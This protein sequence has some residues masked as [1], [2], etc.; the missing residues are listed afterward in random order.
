MVDLLLAAGALAW[1][2][3]PHDVA[4]FVAVNGKVVATQEVDHLALS[5]DGGA[6]WN[7]L[8]APVGTLRCAWVLDNGSVLA[9]GS[10]GLART[11]DGG[12]VWTS[13]SGPANVRICRRDSTGF[14]LG[15]ADAVW[16]SPDGENWVASETDGSVANVVEGPNHALWALLED[17]RIYRRDGGSRDTGGDSAGDTSSDSGRPTEWQLVRADGRAIASDGRTL[18]IADA[19]TLSA[20]SDGTTFSDVTGAPSGILAL[21]VS[22]D[23]IAAA[24]ATEAAWLSED[25]GATWTFVH[26]GIDERSSGVGSPDD[27]VHYADLLVDGD[28]VWLASWEG[29]YSLV[30]GASRWTQAELRTIPLNVSVQWLADGSLLTAVYGGGVY[31][32]LPGETGWL[33]VSEGIDWPWPRQI[34]ATEGGSGAWFVVGGKN[35]YRSDDVGHTW[36]VVHTG[37]ETVGDWASVAATWPSDGRIAVAGTAGGTGAVATSSDGGQTWSQVALSDPCT[38]KP[39]AVVVLADRVLAVCE[40]VLW[41]GDSG[42]A[43]YTFGTEAHMLVPDG[44]GALIATGDGVYQLRPPLEDGPIREAFSGL[45]VS[46]VRRDA[47]GDL[48]ATTS[49]GVVHTAGGEPVYSGWPTRDLSGTIDISSDGVIAVGTYD[50]S[51]VT[52]DGKRWSRAT[53]WDRFDDGDQSWWFDHWGLT[54]EATAKGG[55]AHAGIKGQ[56]AEWVVDGEILALRGWGEGTVEIAVDGISDGGVRVPPTPNKSFWS[57]RVGSG[58]HT[59]SVDVIDGA[60]AI[61][62]GERWRDAPGAVPLTAAPDCGC[63]STPPTLWTALP[64]FLCLRRRKPRAATD[65]P[66]RL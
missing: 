4:G 11:D 65:S 39:N 59:V 37:L 53:D 61:D 7:H 31:R 52:S 15:A 43:L 57:K 47:A 38:R 9:A 22:G 50:G 54:T 49:V 46:D 60:I 58:R 24:T 20:S 34:L 48:W 44:D 33:D 56:H 25:A 32:G 29:L 13:V 2:H 62:G 26:A 55:V 51:F 30:K 45:D 27:G 18:L 5:G 21:S 63:A 66:P 17:A 23:R 64:A 42:V 3:S 12:G 6:H 40:G 8:A 41:D 19:T 14:L 28:T 10:A 35:L 1:A 16:E 36:G